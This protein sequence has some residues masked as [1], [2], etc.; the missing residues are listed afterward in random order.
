MLVGLVFDDIM[1][2]MSS[3]NSVDMVYLDFARHLTRLTMEFSSIKSKLLV[4]LVD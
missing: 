2:L 1:H 4:S 3:G